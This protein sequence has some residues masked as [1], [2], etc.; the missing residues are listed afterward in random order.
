MHA[1]SNST[2]NQ[3]LI[4]ESDEKGKTGRSRNAGVD[5]TKKVLCKGAGEFQLY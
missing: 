5:Y 4:T 3:I 2:E 1:I